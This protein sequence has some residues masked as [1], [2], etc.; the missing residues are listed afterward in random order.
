MTI[1]DPEL[2]PYVYQLTKYDPADRDERG[3]YIGSEDTDSDRGPVEAAY[4]AAVAAFAED[5]QISRLAIRE[6]EAAV[7]VG[8]DGDGR[9]S[10]LA[11][12]FGPDLSGYHDGAQVPVAVGLELVRLMLRGGPGWCRLEAEEDFF[13]H[14]GW[15]QYVYIGST[16]PC[17]RAVA[18][19]HRHRLFAKRIA[20]SPY[21]PALTEDNASPRPADSGFWDEVATI[22][23]ERGAVLL[24][25]GYVYN[26]ARWHRITTSNVNAIRTRL[27]PRARL[28]VWP[29]LQTNI[30]AALASLPDEA[31]VRSFGRTTTV[32]STADALM[33]RTTVHCAAGW[34]TPMPPSSCPRSWTNVTRC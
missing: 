24:E 15:D 2:L 25:E 3:H 34:P 27:T 12:L 20:Q 28:L 22:A 10:R 19:A 23:A 33:K 16:D 31:L 26:A 14:V 13:V 9:D 7:R 4:L 5:S 30:D 32:R 21:D 8:L 6:P 29:D 18:H 17:E 1:D 11:V